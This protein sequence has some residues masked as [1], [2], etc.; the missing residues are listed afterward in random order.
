MNAVKE[1][2]KILI[3]ECSRK[4]TPIYDSIED[5]EQR[6]IVERLGSDIM[7]C[8]NRTGVD[9]NA[10]LDEIK[11]EI[12]GLSSKQREVNDMGA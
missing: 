3:W 9:V 7:W 12:E 8:C 10:L 6:R 1:I 4:I 2:V 5:E 11:D